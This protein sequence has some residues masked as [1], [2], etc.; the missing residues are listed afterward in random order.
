[1]SKK[2]SLC[3]VIAAMAFVLL[4]CST[5]Q[6]P[7][8]EPQAP[9][10]DIGQQPT[11]STQPPTDPIVEQLGEMSLED[12]LGQLMI[13]GLEGT[14]MQE[15]ARAM[16]KEHKIGG[17]ILYKNNIASASATVELLDELKTANLG[18]PAPLWLS[19]DQEGGKVS[20]MPQEFISLPSAREVA[21]RADLDYAYGIGEALG[22]QIGSLGFNMNFAPVLDID[23][24]P[25]NPVIGDRAYGSTPDSVIETGIAVME[26]LQSQDVAAVVKHFPGHGDTSVDS[27]L[28]LPVVNKSLDE[29]EAFELLPF[30]EAIQQQADAVM[31]AHLLIP[32]LDEKL[33]ASLSYAVIT[34]LLR[35]KL[36][37]DGV[38][39]TDDMTMGGIV[40]HYNIGE[41]AVQS[42]LAGSDIVLVGHDTQLQLQVLQAL[43]ASAQS[44]QLSEERIDESVY[45]VLKLKSRYSL[46]DEVLRRVDTAAVNKQIQAVLG[47]TD[48]GE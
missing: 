23:S 25:D 3:L 7:A 9:P 1:M 28:D 35:D 39:M 27:H 18:N 16:I 31:V 45:R 11:P 22:A 33:P 36:G 2:L 15:D 24:N 21:A 4:S 17:F 41:A 43:R 14:S 10:A 40:K 32:A 47:S 38:V 37:Y 6:Q 48:K 19:V 26:G 12:K 8:P 34:G 5:G 29:L 30:V 20:R 46:Q 44:G 42:I 13:V